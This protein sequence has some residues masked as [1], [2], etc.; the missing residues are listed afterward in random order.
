MNARIHS[1]SDIAEAVSS[2]AWS[3]CEEIIESFE[4]AWRSGTTPRITDYLWSEGAIRTALLME[5]IYVE[6]ELRIKSGQTVRPQSYFDAF[7]ELASID[8]LQADLRAEVQA[9]QNRFVTKA[10]D[11]NLSKQITRNGGQ[12]RFDSSTSR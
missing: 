4:N 11:F 10:D 9:L 6:L 3:H 1:R 12:T 2:P 8:R 7:P 5:L